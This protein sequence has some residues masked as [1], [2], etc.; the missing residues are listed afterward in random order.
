MEYLIYLAVLNSNVSNTSDI[1]QKLSI[2]II[3]L[4][5][6]I[7]HMIFKFVGKYEYI[8]VNGIWKWNVLLSSWSWLD[9]TCISMI[10]YYTN[11]GQLNC[12]MDIFCVTYESMEV[13]TDSRSV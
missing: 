2:A 1:F 9:G 8:T 12:L 13:G 5:K 3:S 10:R 4:K 11:A 6:C 7:K